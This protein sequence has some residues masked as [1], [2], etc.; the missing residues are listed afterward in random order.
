MYWV[1]PLVGGAVAALLYDL[2]F[3]VNACRDKFKAFFT[4][5]FYDEAD[6]SSDGANIIHIVKEIPDVKTASV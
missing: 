4:S 1:G 3:A 6:Y 5:K 2:V